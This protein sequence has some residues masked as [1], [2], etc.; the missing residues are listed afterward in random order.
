MST[1]SALWTPL[2]GRATHMCFSYVGMQ[3]VFQVQGLFK[4][5]ARAM[6]R[7]RL[8]S[9]C[10]TQHKPSE[11]VS[12]CGINLCAFQQT[13]ITVLKRFY[14]LMYIMIPHLFLLNIVYDS[15]V[16]W[17]S[18]FSD[19]LMMLIYQN[20]EAYDSHCSKE[21]RRAFVMISC[22]RDKVVTKRWI[23]GSN[24]CNSLD[25]N[26]LVNYLNSVGVVTQA[27][28][29]PDMLLSH[30]SILHTVFWCVLKWMYLFPL[31][32]PAGGASGGKGEATGLFLPF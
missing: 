19:D 1:A 7:R 28:V 12:L 6:P 25:S 9:A 10:T 30:F 27:C 32:G 21:N 4:W 23:I 13:G 29:P 3:E 24:I 26:L 20:G 16:K 8:W 2:Q 14:W 18:F 22:N 5:T 15:L 11:E 31:P 17:Q